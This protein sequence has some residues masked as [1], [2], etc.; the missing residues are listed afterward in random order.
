MGALRQPSWTTERPLAFMTDADPA[1]E[2]VPVDERIEV[3]G[4]ERRVLIESVEW[5]D[6]KHWFAALPA[7]DRNLAAKQARPASQVTPLGREPLL[8]R[9]VPIRPKATASPA[10]WKLLLYDTELGFGGPT[11]FP[12]ATNNN[13]FSVVDDSRIVAMQQTPEFLRAYWRAFKDAVDGPM[14]AGKYASAVDGNTSGLQAIGMSVPSNASMKTWIDGRR[15]YL[16]GELAK[17]AAPFDIL[18]QSG[19]TNSSANLVLIAKAPIEV[20]FVRIN[21]AI[22]NAAVSWFS[23]TNWSLNYTLTNGA[24]PIAA[25]AYDRKT[26]AITGMTNSVTIYH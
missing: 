16:S 2:G 24:N 18:N 20:R 8:A 7:V 17:L 21:G 15:N 13:V 9:N 22:T 1:R 26:N 19:S 5:Q 3:I 11:F 10:R 14:Q 25:Q 6:S 4:G 23:V 12:E